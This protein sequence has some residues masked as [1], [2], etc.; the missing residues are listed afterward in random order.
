MLNVDQLFRSS[1]YLVEGL[2]QTVLL[3]LSAIVTLQPR[4][5]GRK[6][7]A[8]RMRRGGQ[9]PSSLTLLFLACVLVLVS[10]I[11]PRTRI[12]AEQ[13][14][15]LLQG[16]A[17]PK[18]AIGAL[19]VAGVIDLVVRMAVGRS[20]RS[21]RRTALFRDTVASWLML[22]AA[23]LFAFGVAL[24]ADPSEPLTS[25]FASSDAAR[26]TVI[27]LSVGFPSVLLFPMILKEK[28]RHWIPK[29]ALVAFAACFLFI[30]TLMAA[31]EWEFARDARGHP[32]ISVTRTICSVVAGKLR[33]HV[34]LRNIGADPIW[35]ADVAQDQIQLFRGGGITYRREPYQVYGGVY[36]KTITI[37]F[38][39]ETAGLIAPGSTMTWAGESEQPVSPPGGLW[40][41]RYN[42]LRAAALRDLP[43]RV[44]VSEPADEHNATA[45]GPANNAVEAQ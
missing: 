19:F 31:L 13:A 3:T 10:I 8:A 7:A 38:E 44:P 45:P 20:S 14:T 2:I 22:L 17:L 43:D 21:P 1:V 9:F 26:W 18:L 41:C 39:G 42:G 23:G 15:S 40:T 12:A 33:V 36:Y 35:V 25:V 28:V 5:I 11:D 24:R 16:S 32:S 4:K 29:F 27:V 37:F 34:E 30:A 6:I